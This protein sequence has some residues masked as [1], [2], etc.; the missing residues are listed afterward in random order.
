MALKPWYKVISPREDLR[1]GKP[2]DRAFVDYKSKYGGVKED[3]FALL[4]L[5]EEFGKPVHDVARQVAFGTN[6]FGIDAFHFDRDRRNLYLFQFK[7]SENYQ[8]FKESLTRLASAGMERV[9]G[10]PHQIQDQNGRLVTL[11]PPKPCV[12]AL[13]AS[14]PAPAA[15]PP[16]AAA[17]TSLASATREAVYPAQVLLY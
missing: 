1:D 12:A 16:V 10:N 14:T 11:K 5:A 3:Y 2:L 13:S 15:G 17:S 9:F 6:D 4:Y 7:W 8:L